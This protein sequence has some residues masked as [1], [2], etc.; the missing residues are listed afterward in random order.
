MSQL[1][2]DDPLP[3]PNRAFLLHQ[4]AENMKQRLVRVQLTISVNR[5]IE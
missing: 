3:Q 2:H 4:I 1:S 5:R